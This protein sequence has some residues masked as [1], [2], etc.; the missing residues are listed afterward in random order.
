MKPVLDWA[1]KNRGKLLGAVFAALYALGVD[2]A[3]V[4]RNGSGSILDL[5]R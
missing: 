2:P 4:C 1:V 5:L 3:E